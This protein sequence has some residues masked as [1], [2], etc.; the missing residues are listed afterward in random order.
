MTLILKF[1][2]LFYVDIVILALFTCSF[3]YMTSGYLA[4][5]S[6]IAFNY[7][8]MLFLIRITRCP[9]STLDNFTIKRNTDK[10]AVYCTRKFVIWAGNY[11][12]VKPYRYLNQLRMNR[13]LC[14]VWQNWLCI[15]LC[16]FLDISATWESSFP[17]NLTQLI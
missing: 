15:L 11:S 7:R 2:L 5:M 10:K 14:Y 3:C 17:R 12:S 9:L 1:E 6:K 4:D 16:A 13:T 8:C